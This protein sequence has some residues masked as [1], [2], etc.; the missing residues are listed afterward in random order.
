[1]PARAWSSRTTVCHDNAAGL[2]HGGTLA[3]VVRGAIHNPPHLWKQQYC[4]G[5][6]G[7]WA[8]RHLDGVALSFCTFTFGHMCDI[9]RDSHRDTGQ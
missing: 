7:T 9:Y 4:S 8:V 3:I 5:A 6:V 1:M 2:E